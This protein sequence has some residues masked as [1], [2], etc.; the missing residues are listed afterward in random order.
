[1]SSEQ[2]KTNGDCTKCRK[3]KY[4]SHQCTANKR[5]IQKELT[6]RIIGYLTKKLGGAE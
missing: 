5:A 1:M 6:N 2:W 4:C 3:Q